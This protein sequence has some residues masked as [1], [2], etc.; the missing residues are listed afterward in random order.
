MEV[1]LTGRS[2]SGRFRRLPP[3][4]P[5]QLPTLPDRG[6]G[7]QPPPRRTKTRRTRR[8]VRP[9]SAQRL[10]QLGHV[11]LPTGVFS[12]IGNPR[13]RDGRPGGS[14]TEVLQDLL[15]HLLLG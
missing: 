4:S 10:L 6:R 7:L 3:A 1:E 8:P 15:H 14:K 9:P 5:V 12:C 2:I 11:V 13:G